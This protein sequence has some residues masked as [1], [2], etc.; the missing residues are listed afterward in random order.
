MIHYYYGDGK[1]K[2]TAAMGLA[3]RALG[4]GKRVFIVQFLKSTPSGEALFFEGLPGVTVR[5]GKAG[6]GFTF[7]MTDTEKAETVRIHDSNLVE[8]MAAVD[9]GSCDMLILDEVGDAF[10]AAM[11]DQAALLAFLGRIPAA[12][13][14]VMT[15]HRPVEPLTARADYV[16]HMCKEKHPYDRGQA[17]R[18]G[19][20][21]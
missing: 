8:G 2:T 9:E 10:A 20:E 15:G 18:A 13:E 14:I 7:S 12:T 4:R 19:V 6:A 11:L 5:R 1:G 3:V 21:Y 17:A 16:T